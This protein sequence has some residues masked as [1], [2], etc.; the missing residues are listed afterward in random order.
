MHAAT[1]ESCFALSCAVCSAPLRFHSSIEARR[2][3]WIFSRRPRT[4][5]HWNWPCIPFDEHSNG[6]ILNGWPSRHSFLSHSA[7]ESARYRS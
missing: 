6:I 2:A 4:C 1:C 7:R 3:A 5:P